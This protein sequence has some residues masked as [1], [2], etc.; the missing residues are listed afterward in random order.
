MRANRRADTQEKQLKV[1]GE[2]INHVSQYKYLGSI[3]TKN[4]DCAVDINTR[5]A[6]AKKKT[7]ELS[8]LWK[9]CGFRKEVKVKLVKVLI[10]PV[11]TCGAEA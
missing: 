6:L 4:G 11:I 7:V 2:N 5:I 9:D 1:N 10:W 3:K 8:A